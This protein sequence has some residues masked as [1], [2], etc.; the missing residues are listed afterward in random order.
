VEGQRGF[1]KRYRSL[2]VL[3]GHPYLMLVKSGIE[4]RTTLHEELRQTNKWLGQARL[5]S[6]TLT[7]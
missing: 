2:S 7:L 5:V 1:T 4:G 6:F 3:L